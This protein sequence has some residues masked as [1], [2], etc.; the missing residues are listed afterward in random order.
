MDAKSAKGLEMDKAEVRD[1][2]RNLRNLWMSDGYCP[3]IRH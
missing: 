1:N 2:L 3:D